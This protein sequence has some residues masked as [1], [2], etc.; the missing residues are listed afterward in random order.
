MNLIGRYVFRMSLVAFLATVTVLTGVVWVTQALREIDLMTA[1][2][3]TVSLFLSFTVLALPALIMVIA[4]VALVIACLYML[5]RLNADSELVVVSAAGISPWHVVRPLAVLGVI[6]TVLAAFISLYL[7][8]ESARALRTLITQVRADVL[9]SIVREGRFTTVEDGLTFH[10]RDRLNDGTLVGLI[11]HDERE[12]EKVMTYL[13][14]EGMIVRSDTNAYLV[15]DEGSIQQRGQQ[16]EKISIV[17]FDRYVFDLSN[18]SEGGGASYLEPREMR[19]GELLDPDPE[20]PYVKHKPGRVRAEL[21]ERLS[22][23]LYPLAFTFVALAALGRPRTNR[24]GRG[25][26]LLAAI[27]TVATL[28]TAGFA[29]TNLAR[30]EAWAVVPMY[31]APGAVI[32]VAGWAS[33]DQSGR[34]HALLQP[35]AIRWH[36]LTSALQ[37][38]PL[39]YQNAFAGAQKRHGR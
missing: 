7:M 27:V 37:H 24:Q 9:T 16:A 19:M 39:R 25:K 30:S 4:P 36:R 5:N 33:L 21:H 32:L 38:A 31:A 3:Q 13:A 29:F 22:S 1:K 2:G 15:M 11:V 6:V 17:R 20:N 23:I 28:R 18:L 12:P 34:A 26:A 14:E 8:P 10:I 35:L